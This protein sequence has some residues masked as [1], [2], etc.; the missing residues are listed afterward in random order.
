MTTLQRALEVIA[1]NAGHRYLAGA[2]IE[3]ARAGAIAEFS[4]RFPALGRQV[5]EALR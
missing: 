1:E 4:Q 3:Q 2:T 5:A